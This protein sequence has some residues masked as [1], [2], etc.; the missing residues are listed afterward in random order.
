MAAAIPIILSGVA[1]TAVSYY[2]Q[3]EAGEEE[4]AARNIEAAAV[5]RQGVEEEKASRLKLKKLLASQRALFAKAGVDLSTGSPLT[6]LAH[7]AAE[8][9][10][11]AIDIRRG[12]KEQADI[13]RFQGSAAKRASRTRATGTL[14]SGLASTGGSAYTVT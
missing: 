2:G 13:L 8:G 9:E 10:K 5:E 12:A 7:T 1:T 6:I 11:Q 3:R 14:L 4:Q